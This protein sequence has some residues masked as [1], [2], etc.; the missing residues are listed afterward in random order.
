MDT[1]DIAIAAAIVKGKVKRADEAAQAAEKAADDAKAAT[2][3][4]YH[5]KNF[6]LSVNADNSL[7][8]SYDPDA[9]D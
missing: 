7:T 1:H 2:A 6:L 4:I 5:D 3:A 8:L 9:N